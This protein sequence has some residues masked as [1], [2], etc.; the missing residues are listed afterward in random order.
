MATEG[1][2]YVHLHY[3]A[4]DSTWPPGSSAPNI[5]KASKGT[6]AKTWKASDS[7]PHDCFQ[8]KK[9]KD[10][11]EDSD[12]KVGLMGCSWGFRTRNIERRKSTQRETIESIEARKP[13]ETGDYALGLDPRDAGK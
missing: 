6:G 9:S 7:L 13:D 11:A 3:T 10:D 1:R 8:E 12:K 4:A 2:I 5:L